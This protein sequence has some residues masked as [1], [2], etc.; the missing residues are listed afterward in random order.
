MLIQFSLKVN[1]NNN[2]VKA[3]NWYC[4]IS[5]EQ[6]LKLIYEHQIKKIGLLMEMLIQT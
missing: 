4:Q 5:T 6:I 3:I 2:C 1:K